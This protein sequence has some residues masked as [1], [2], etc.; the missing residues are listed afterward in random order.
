MSQQLFNQS[1]TS[2]LKSDTETAYQWLP[3]A[4]T[5]AD[6]EQEDAPLVFVNRAFERMTGY[7][8]Q[9]VVV[10]NCRF[11]QGEKTDG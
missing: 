7:S 1:S 6:L 10:R 9:A 4:L 5:I 3:F 2:D 8:S 11:L